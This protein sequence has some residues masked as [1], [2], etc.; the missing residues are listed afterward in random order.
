V[1]ASGMIRTQMWTHNRSEMIAVLGTP[2]EIPPRNNNSY[3][4]RV[5]ALKTTDVSVAAL[6]N[7]VLNLYLSSNFLN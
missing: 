7:K 6:T 3:S 5:I 4:T 2:F 1:H